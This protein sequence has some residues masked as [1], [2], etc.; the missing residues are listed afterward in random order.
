MWPLLRRRGNLDGPDLIIREMVLE[1]LPEVTKIENDLFTDPW[2]PVIFAEDVV[3]VTSYPFVAQIDNTIVGYAIL[4]L[5]V[6]EGHLTNIAVSKKYQRKSIAKTLLSYILRFA[7]G[8]GLGQIILEVR[9]SN[10][11]AISLYEAYG[12]ETLSIRKNYYRNPAEDCLVMRK[13]IQRGE[14]R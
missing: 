8:L 14:D 1:D 3:S 5:G 10:A 7:S 4:W 12:F 11:P 6:D 13:I 9:P 2:P